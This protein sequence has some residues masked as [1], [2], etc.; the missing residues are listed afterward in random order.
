MNEVY[1]LDRV[2]EAYDRMLSGKARLRAR[3]A[4]GA[5]AVPVVGNQGDLLR[6]PAERT[7]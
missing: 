3:A 5:V 1:P 4:D 7:S 6:L 2:A